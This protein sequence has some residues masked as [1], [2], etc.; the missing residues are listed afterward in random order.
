MH[1]EGFEALEQIARDNKN[2][3]HFSIINDRGWKFF[4]TDHHYTCELVAP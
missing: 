4:I 1:A 3:F 2:A